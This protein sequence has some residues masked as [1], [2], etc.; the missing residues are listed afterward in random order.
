MDN[1]KLNSLK[2]EEESYLQM[3]ETDVIMGGMIVTKTIKTTK[4]NEI[5]AFIELEDLYG[6]I[7]II[8]F[9]NYYKSIMSF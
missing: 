8:V 6:A 9:L 1:G 4:R 3:N 2:E 7:E 5:M